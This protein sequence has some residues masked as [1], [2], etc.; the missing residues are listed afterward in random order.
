MLNN[1]HYF[2]TL[3][4][5][6]NISRAAEKLWIETPQDERAQRF[7]AAALAPAYH[8]LPQAERERLAREN[9]NK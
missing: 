4:E 6:L 5:E 7:A 8:R 1:Y 9:E 2:I 3:A